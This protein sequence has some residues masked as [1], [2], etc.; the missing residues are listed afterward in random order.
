MG[1]TP[2]YRGYIAW[3]YAI[4]YNK[5]REACKNIFLKIFVHSLGLIL[6]IVGIYFL[7]I[8]MP[9]IISIGGLIIIFIG[10]FIFLIP[11]GV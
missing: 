2:G 11:L 4:I 1:Q 8:T 6:M 9:S 7:I 5:I 10:L 3:F